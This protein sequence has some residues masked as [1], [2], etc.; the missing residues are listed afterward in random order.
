MRQL[1]SWMVLW[2]SVCTS[3]MAGDW[4]A[5]VEKHGE[6]LSPMQS[7]QLG[8]ALE[9]SGSNLGQW[10]TALDQCQTVEEK[11]SLVFLLSFMP[12][13]D[14][15]QL[16]AEFVLENIR[17]AWQAREELAF[18]QTV[19]LEV[20]YNDVLPYAVLNETRDAWRKPLFDKL[21]PLVSACQTLRE[22]AVLVNAQ[23]KDVVNVKYSTKRERADQSPLE[24]MASG[25]ASCSGLSI[26]LTDAFRAV[27]IPSRIAGIPAWP[28]KPGNHNWSEVWIDGEWLVTEYYPDEKGFNHGWLL[29]DILYAESNHWHHRVY[30]SSF[31]PTEFWFPLVWDFNIR[32]VHGV[33]VT[34][35]YI[36]LALSQGLK[37]PSRGRVAFVVTDA[38]G[39][40]VATKIRI[41]QGETLIFEGV[42]ADALADL[43]AMLE[44]TLE[45]GK[46]Y[47][48]SYF[49]ENG[50]EAQLEFVVPDQK[51]VKVIEVAQ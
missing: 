5:V 41:T 43:N 13:R 48:L 11:T 30:A 8:K 45:P 18:A 47:Q 35:R 4:Q 1:V 39:E 33:D 31:M 12:E 26:L 36:E 51:R 25:L 6:G 23:L 34:D 46:T 27:G 28:H 14:L 32:F 17:L 38:K 16:K 9:K 49:K 29:G 42:T 2:L 37:M 24:S 10:S 20:F 15:L 22:A 3:L 50:D 19:P 40:R 21:K 44:T 7:F